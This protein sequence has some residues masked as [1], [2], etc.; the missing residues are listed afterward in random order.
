MKDDQ[1]YHDEVT[2]EM[3]E[4][5]DGKINGVTLAIVILIIL[6]VTVVVLIFIIRFKASRKKPDVSLT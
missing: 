4:N 6:V 5:T 1:E 3:A 2:M